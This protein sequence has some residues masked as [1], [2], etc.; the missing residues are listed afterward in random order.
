MVPLP[1]AGVG[2]TPVFLTLHFKSEFVF[3]KKKAS[4]S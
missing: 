4:K 2:G 1:I 3:L